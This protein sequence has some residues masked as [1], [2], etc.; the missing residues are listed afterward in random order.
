MARRVQLKSLIRKNP[1]A[2][3]I[4]QWIFDPA[5][6]PT[7]LVDDW[8]RQQDGIVLNFGA[9]SRKFPPK[10]L[11]LDI[12]PFANV[13]IVNSRDG[14][15]L[16]YILEYIDSCDDLLKEVLRV[17]KVGAPILVTARKPG[18]YTPN[19]ILDF[20]PMGVDQ[21]LWAL[22]GYLLRYENEISWIDKV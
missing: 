1:E 13:Q 19:R 10:V 2:A 16:E 12:E 20:S 6:I 14:V 22:P 17:L 4:L 21:L 18:A 11:T 5:Y 8:I 3:K 9:G 15:L 7:H